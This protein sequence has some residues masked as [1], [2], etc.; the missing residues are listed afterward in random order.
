MGMLVPA[1]LEGHGSVKKKLEGVIPAPLTPLTEQGR[2]DFSL[3]QKQISWF[4][5][6]GVNGLFVCGTTGEGAYLTTA[7]KRDIFTAVREVTGTR[8]PLCLACIQPSTSQVLEE[9]AALESLEPDFVVAVTPFY[10]GMPQEAILAHFRDIARR[11]PVPVI[12]YNIP[13]CTHNP[14]A[15][16]TVLELAHAQ[17]IAGVKDSSG[18]FVS[19]TRGLLASVPAHF[20]WIMGED[21]LDGPAL[22]AGADGI[23]SGLSNVWVQFY[24]DLYRAAAAGE[25][26]GVKKSQARIDR[27][28]AIHRVTGGKVIPVLKAGASFFGRCSLRMKIPSLTLSEGEA[29]AVRSVLRELQIL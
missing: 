12:L 20:S 2:V 17:N 11:S 23:V 16:E 24:V 27:L 6:A 1:G 10:Y 3:L 13:Q 5:Q 21:A 19:F 25:R 9:L 8:V 18:D 26:E 15:V 4:L 28:Y 22:L 7:E 14:V 29:Q